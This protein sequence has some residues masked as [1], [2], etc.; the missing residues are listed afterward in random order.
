MITLVCWFLD[1]QN[2]VCIL[3][4]GSRN[5]QLHAI[6]LECL[7]LLSKYQIHLEPEWIPSE[8][9]E[10]ADYLNR[11]IDYD[12]W[13]LNPAEFRWLDAIK[14]AITV[15]ASCHASTACTGAPLRKQ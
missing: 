15:I 13:Y 11:I 10:R 5:P 6:A 7:M 3:Q 12:D 1:N 8:L 14:L 4:V 9:N 2:A